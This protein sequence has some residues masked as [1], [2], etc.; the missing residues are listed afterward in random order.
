MLLLSFF[1]INFVL[2]SSNQI[3]IIK[4]YLTFKNR[5]N[6]TLS[7]TFIL[8][9][10]YLINCELISPKLYE[11]YKKN[12][13]EIRNNFKL[14]IPSIN[15]FHIGDELSIFFD[16]NEDNYYQNVEAIIY[17][18]NQF[19]KSETAFI[20]Y[21]KLG[22]N[23][24]FINGLR[25]KMNKIEK[26]KTIFQKFTYHIEKQN[27][28]TILLDKE[29]YNTLSLIKS[30]E[31]DFRHEGHK[32]VIHYV[33]FLIL[34][35]TSNKIILRKKNQK[36]Y[37]YKNIFLFIYSI[38]IYLINSYLVYALNNGIINIYYYYLINIIPLYFFI[39]YVFKKYDN[40]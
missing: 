29:H 26:S 6:A 21:D 28:E 33:F 14:G 4:Q 34:I 8:L 1:Y 20:E 38:L 5:K 25:I 18:D 10:F 36:L 9:I 35:L 12:E 13:V 15:E 27:L 11:I 17:K 31:K 40:Q 39:H 7:I 23:I 16:E 19:I 32:R 22:F 3:V 24:I 37:D 2:N 30:D